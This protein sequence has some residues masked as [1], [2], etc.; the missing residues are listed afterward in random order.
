[1]EF[2]TTNTTSKKVKNADRRVF[3]IIRYFGHLFSRER[4]KTNNDYITPTEAKCPI[5]ILAC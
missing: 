5:Y 2:I 4:K 1:M 3:H